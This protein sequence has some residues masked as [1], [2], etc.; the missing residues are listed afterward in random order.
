MAVGHSVTAVRGDLIHQS[1]LQGDHLVPCGALGGPAEL[2][3]KKVAKVAVPGDALAPDIAADAVHVAH[4]LAARG[5][6]LS[7][8]LKTRRPRW[9]V[10]GYALTENVTT[11]IPLIVSANIFESGNYGTFVC[12]VLLS[13]NARKRRKEKENSL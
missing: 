7:L 6:T 13:E 1:R 10:T 9:Y 5:G 11:R 2:S 4:C 3:G 12:S 8:L